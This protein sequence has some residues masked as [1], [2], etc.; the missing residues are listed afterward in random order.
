MKKIKNTIKFISIILITILVILVFFQIRTNATTGKSTAEYVRVREK[1]SA[2]SEVIDL[3]DKDDTFQV[4]G[5][6][7]DWYKVLFKGKTGYVSKAYVSVNGKV[8]TTSQLNENNDSDNKENKNEQAQNSENNQNINDQPQN[9]ENNKDANEQTQNKENNSDENEQAQKTENNS[10]ASEQ[11]SSNTSNNSL[12]KKMYKIAD[13]SKLNILPLINSQIVGEVKKNEEVE[14]LENAGLWGFIKANNSYG[15]IRTEKLTGENIITI[16]NNDNTSNSDNSEN[17]ENNI[18]KNN[19]NNNTEKDNN[20]G[21]NDNNNNMN[22]NN[23]DKNNQNAENKNQQTQTVNYDS[24]KTMYVKAE[25]VNIKTN[26][27]VNSDIVNGLQRN[28]SIKVIGEENDWYKV[29]FNGDYGFIRKDLLSS[30]KTEVT[31]RANDFNRTQAVTQQ[32]A[33][34][35]A[36]QNTQQNTQQNVPVSSTGVSGT[37]IANYAQQ[38]VGCRYVYGAAGPSSFDCSGL[39]MY[40]YKHFGYNLSHSSKVQATQG[41]PVSGDLQPGDIL[42]FSNDG[43][44][45]GHVGIYIGND[46]FVHA[47][48]STT[49]VIISNLHDKCNIKKYWGAR[50]IL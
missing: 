9:T 7:G 27:T 17:T 48:D 38:F 25:A 47:S 23:K 20:D 28:E 16:N 31:S 5:E 42:V 10:N 13:D 45:V 34:Q 21:N 35:N 4:L 8:E 46:K 37:D 18:D 12:Y 50:R 3:L 43:K 14:L 6:E 32:N 41:K 15:W 44:T 33:Q 39:T 40:V 19:Q 49:G 24:A 29:E 36:Q 22:D 11:N 30:E 26:S 1:A 2:Q